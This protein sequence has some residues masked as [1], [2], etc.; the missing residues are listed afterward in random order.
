MSTC[1]TV[2]VTI[3]LTESDDEEDD[4]TVN[5][6]IDL[7]ESD[8]ESVGS[9]I[10]LTQSDN[11]MD[12]DDGSIDSVHTH[13]DLTES[14]DEIDDAVNVTVTETQVGECYDIDI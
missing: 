11:E 7:T 12:S 3:H 9:V 1:F 6:V 4:T 13:Y 5:T 2:T 14:D 8:D 10:D